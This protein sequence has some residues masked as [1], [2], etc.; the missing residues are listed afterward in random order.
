MANENEKRKFDIIS[1][2]RF[3]Y[4]DTPQE[5]SEK[6]GF[7]C[8]EFDNGTVVRTV[9]DGIEFC[10]ERFVG[11]FVYGQD[12]SFHYCML[13]PITDITDNWQNERKA[14]A[15]FHICDKIVSN[16]GKCVGRFKIDVIKQGFRDASSTA[17][18]YFLLVK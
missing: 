11:Q 4:F 7:I 15:E 8:H 1:R 13:H 16:I 17:E 10:G 2:M 5:L 18:R 6:Y 3:G 12:N 14:L 9:S